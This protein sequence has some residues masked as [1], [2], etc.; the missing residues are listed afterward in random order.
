MTRLRP[1]TDASAGSITFVSRPTMADVIGS[2]V[3]LTRWSLFSS[4]AGTFACVNALFA[5]VVTGDRLSI[6]FLLLG[7]SFL[8]GVFIVPFAWWALHQRRDLVLAE[9]EVLA[10]DA[11]I[12]L[13]TA[14]STGRHDWSVF[15]QV[16]ETSGAF[17]LDTGAGAA[18]LIVKRGA[19][20]ASIEGLRRLLIAAGKVPPDGRRRDL[21]R[22]VFGV[23]IGLA[24]TAVLIGSAILFGP[25]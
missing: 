14:A 8:T 22:T 3:V 9:V 19:D 4:A 25:R 18:V 5:I 6:L 24:A 15:R 23:A 1:V 10:D 13:T 2:A 21:R 16:R 20:A 7:L 12:T 11:G 17:V